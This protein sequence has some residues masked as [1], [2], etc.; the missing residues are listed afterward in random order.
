MKFTITYQRVIVDT[1]EAKDIDHAARMAC[2]AVMNL[3]KDYCARVLSIYRDDA[4]PLL[5]PTTLRPF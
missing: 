1:V 2:A 4:A 5:L 3:P